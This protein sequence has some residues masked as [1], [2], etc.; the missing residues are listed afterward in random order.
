MYIC[1]YVV[2]YAYVCMYNNV[3]LFRLHSDTSAELKRSMRAELN[4]PNITICII[5]VFEYILVL[6]RVRHLVNS[7][8]VIRQKM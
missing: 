6:I 2:R 3:I 1:M 5:A 7:T 4:W 8:R